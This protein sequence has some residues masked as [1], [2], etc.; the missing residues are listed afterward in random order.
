[1]TSVSKYRPGA[2]RRQVASVAVYVAVVL[3]L[4]AGAA[5]LVAGLFA[6]ADEVADA[7]D[8][9][10]RLDGREPPGRSATVAGAAA[11]VGSP[12]LEGRTVTVSGA[13]LQQRIGSA[14]S[15]AGGALLSSQID[16]DGPQSKEGFVELAADV[17]IEQPAL[18]ALLYDIEAGMP[19]LTIDRLAILAPPQAGGD[20]ESREAKLRVSLSVSGQWGGAR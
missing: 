4:T 14:V 8:R 10:A 13:A 19:Y 6:Q 7:Q 3:G 17:Q 1:L 16:L 2:G 9:L 12:F 15:R 11:P 20:S 18:Q 5:W